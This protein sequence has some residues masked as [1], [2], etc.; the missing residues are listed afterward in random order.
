MIDQCSMDESEDTDDDVLS[1][2]VSGTL[3]EETF[4]S[5]AREGDHSNISE[6]MPEITREGKIIEV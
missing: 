1:N 4:P 6:E 3:D 2:L 5:Q